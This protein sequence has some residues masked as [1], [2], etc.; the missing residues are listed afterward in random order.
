[1]EGIN[2]LEIHSGLQPLEI[3]GFRIPLFWIYSSK[4]VYDSGKNPPGH[5]VLLQGHAKPDEITEKVLKEI[6]RIPTEN[7]RRG[8]LEVLLNVDGFD[9]CPE[10][11]AKVARYAEK[12]GISAYVIDRDGKKREIN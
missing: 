2:R 10:T 11:E 7:K 4:V 9:C 8:P 3:F 6:E 1:M 5:R 12:Y